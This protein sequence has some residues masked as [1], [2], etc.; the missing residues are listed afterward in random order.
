MS[1]LPRGLRI[2][3]LGYVQIRIC[4]KGAWY[5]KHFGPDSALSRQLAEIHLAEKRKDILMGRF[6]VSKEPPSRLFKDI[7]EAYY[8]KWSKEKDPEGKLEHGS[9][10][11]TRRVIHSNL[12][13]Y[14]GTRPFESIRPVD[15]QRW[16][17]FR[18]KSVLGT[19]VNREQA[20]LSSIFSHVEQW[21]KTEE[22]EPMKLPPENP[23]KSVKK[24]PNRKRKRVLSVMELKALKAACLEAKDNDLW[25][26]CEMALKS[27]LRKK[28]LFNLEAGFSIDGIQSKT[29]RGIQLPVS[30]LRPLRYE[31]FRK[32]WELVRRSARLV[33][34]QFRDL[35]K[36]GANLLKM[37]NHS[38]KLISEFLGH[39]STRTT[40]IYMVSDTTHL[41]PLAK[42]L[43]DILRS[44]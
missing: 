15:I 41:S 32:R 21:V 27:L 18:L 37:K 1:K 25:E 20:V 26:I 13:P 11:E 16:R 7:A 4:H 34:C 35:R 40:E 5:Q 10:D 42:D 17:E 31:N 8:E 3:K 29:Q 22:W 23:C 9:A 6:G 44:L 2:T 14:F 30:V 36:T 19:S 33:D 43:N 28:D 12:D 38:N 39:A 24:A